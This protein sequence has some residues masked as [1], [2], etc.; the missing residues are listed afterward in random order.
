MPRLSCLA[1]CGFCLVAVAAYADDHP[2][3]VPTRDAAVT[4]R[5]SGAGKNGQDAI[6]HMYLKAG[7]NLLRIDTPG[8]H[9]YAII[10]RRNKEMYMVIDA[11]R[12]YVEL[13]AGDIGDR[14]FMLTD[15]M[16]FRRKGT[17]TVA[18]YTCTIWDVQAQDGS[19]T[20]CV[21]DDGV[22]LRASGRSRSGKG[23]GRLEAIT[24][25]YAPQPAA[26]FAPPSDYKKMEVPVAPGVAPGGSSAPA[27][28]PT[29]QPK[30][31]KP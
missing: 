11:Q 24:V 9:G 10:D 13:P 25:D 8:N 22:M 20:A 4:Y 12:M 26:L 3:L 6:L 23:E 18:G 17:D 29:G 16:K 30:Q 15:S 19:G 7:G 28:P 27:Q 2:P 1:A 5:V 31:D 21:T 14:A